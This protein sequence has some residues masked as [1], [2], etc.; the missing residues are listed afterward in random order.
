MMLSKKSVGEKEVFGFP[1]LKPLFLV[2]M[3]KKTNIGLKIR[4]WGEEEVAEFQSAGEPVTC[5]QKCG[6]RF[7]MIHW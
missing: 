4:W 7:R 1:V 3:S 5:A 2:N 6:K